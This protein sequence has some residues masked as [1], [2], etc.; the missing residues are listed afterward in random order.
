M[1]KKELVIKA[2]DCSSNQLVKAAEKCG[3]IVISKGKHYKVQIS[4]G[5]L[6][7]GVVIKISEFSTHKLIIR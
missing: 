6:V 3:L 1:S 2:S 4:N 7:K 5:I